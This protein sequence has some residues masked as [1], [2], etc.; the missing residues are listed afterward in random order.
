MGKVAVAEVAAA[1]VLKLSDGQTR[2]ES[3]AE[4][5]REYNKLYEVLR[6]IY[7]NLRK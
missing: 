2:S 1:V 3:T 5:R 4:I 6:K 7:R